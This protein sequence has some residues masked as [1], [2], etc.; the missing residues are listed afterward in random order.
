MACKMRERH[1]YGAHRLARLAIFEK[2]KL[3]FCASKNLRDERDGSSFLKGE[4]AQDTSQPCETSETGP[5]FLSGKPAKTS[6]NPRDEQDLNCSSSSNAAC[7]TKPPQPQAFWWP[8]SRKDP[9]SSDGWSGQRP[10]RS[11]QRP[12]SSN[13]N[14]S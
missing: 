5:R 12:Q 8:Q 13:D 10:Q 2:I 14:S 3:S 6:N 9:S 4:T 7:G 1:Y 11:Q